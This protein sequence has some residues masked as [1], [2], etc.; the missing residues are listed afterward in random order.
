MGKNMSNFDII[1]QNLQIQMDQ[2]ESNFDEVTKQKYGI[3]WTN[4]DLAYE[5][6]S[7]LVDTF[8]EDFLE[9][10][11]NKKFL[12]PC[13]GMGSF[14]FAF[15]RKLYEKKISKEQIN[16]V[17][18]NIYFCDIDENI[19]IYFFSC[20]QDFVKNLF[21]LDIDNKLFKSNSAKGLIFNNYSDEYISLEKSFGKDVKFDI[22]IFFERSLML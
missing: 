9:N 11:T 6:V 2:Y 8:D 22:L 21:N 13:V 3:Y 17:I 19:L 14:I 16:K 1:W 4:L 12:E 15:L 18:K 20:Y 10:I 5:I 7:N